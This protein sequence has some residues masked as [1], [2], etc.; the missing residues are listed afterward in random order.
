MST[1][2]TWEGQKLFIYD[3]WS[4]YF[5]HNKSFHI[6]LILLELSD[7]ALLRASNFFDF[8]L[9][10]FSVQFSTQL[11][12]VWTSIQPS[13]LNEAHPLSLSPTTWAFFT[14]PLFLLVPKQQPLLVYLCIFALWFSSE[15]HNP[16]P[17]RDWL[18]GHHVHKPT[19][20]VLYVS[21]WKSNRI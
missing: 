13:E 19:V 16:R 17:L 1:I 2:Q 21:S 4:F 10:F 9:L 14:S 20:N 12:A 5:R 8:F 18:S 6:T 3:C 11:E 15:Q 7:I